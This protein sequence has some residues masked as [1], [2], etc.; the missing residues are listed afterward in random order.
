MKQLPTLLAAW[1]W[2][3]LSNRV[4]YI[5]TPQP[6]RSFTKVIMKT[7]S[8]CV[9]LTLLLG[10]FAQPAKAVLTV[11]TDRGSWEGVVGSFATEDFNALATGPMS[12]GTN[13]AGVIDIQI[14]GLN[15]PR[16]NEI[17]TGA[18]E[19]DFDGSNHI[20]GD[21]SSVSLDVSF[22]ILFDR[23]IA[24]FGADWVSTTTGGLLTMLIDG[25]TVKFSDHM[26][27]NGN[28]FLGVVSDSTF[29]TASFGLE[30]IS[31]NRTNEQFGMDNIAVYVPEPCS[32]VLI[33]LGVLGWCRMV[34]I[35][36]GSARCNP[37]HF[38]D[39]LKLSRF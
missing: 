31:T 39:T 14:G 22:S 32:F 15:A 12:R 13:N 3:V 4:S 20:H 26:S 11:Y 27:G 17:A 2:F 35:G 18:T 34:G 19:F 21:V 28:G 37:P 29:T 9:G 36:R 30:I 6:S 25:E 23:P 38:D 5:M 7:T 16:G 10:A 8:A 33:G 24:G 1:R